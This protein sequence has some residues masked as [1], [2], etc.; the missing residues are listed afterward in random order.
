[1]DMGEL[2]EMWDLYLLYD[3][4]VLHHFACLRLLVRGEDDIKKASGEIGGGGGRQNIIRADANKRMR[5]MGHK[6]V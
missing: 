5:G 2:L 4:P 6:V 3:E 1:M